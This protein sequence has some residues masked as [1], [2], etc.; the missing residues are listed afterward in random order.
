MAEHGTNPRVAQ[1]LFRSPYHAQVLLD[2]KSVWVAQP[3]EELSADTL[4]CCAHRQSAERDLHNGN[5][6]Y[7]RLSVPPQVR[8]R[9]IANCLQI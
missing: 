3:Q 2:R 1:T 6:I 4:S 8:G 9:T 7:G 5:V